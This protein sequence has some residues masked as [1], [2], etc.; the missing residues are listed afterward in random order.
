[1]QTLSPDTT[2]IQLPIA[3]VTTYCLAKAQRKELYTLVNVTCNTLSWEFNY[4]QL[5]C[6]I[7]V[8]AHQRSD[9]SPVVHLMTAEMMQC[10]LSHCLSGNSKTGA[11]DGT[12]QAL[13]RM[14]C[15]HCRLHA[16]YT[17][18]YSEHMT[19]TWL[20]LHSQKR[21]HTTNSATCH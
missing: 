15:L 9:A 13:F 4:A 3:H 18:L 21:V 11:M 20:Q 14:S 8:A 12:G 1:M 10:V 5:I 6:V 16:T 2:D 17:V 19:L 7:F